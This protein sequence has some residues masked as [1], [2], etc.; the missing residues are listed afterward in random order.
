[1]SWDSLQKA[2]L[3]SRGDLRADDVFSYASFVH[4]A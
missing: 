2:G 3:R 4:R 1:M